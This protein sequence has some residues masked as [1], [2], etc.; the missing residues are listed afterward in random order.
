MINLEAQ[1]DFCPKYSIVTRGI[2]YGARMISSQ[3][4]TEFSGSNYD[5]IKKVYSIWIC[6]NV[7]RYIGN[8]I[9]EYSL[10]KQDIVQEMPD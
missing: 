8:T 2:Y 7:P 3:K 6:M 4:G 9:L 1:R 10:T 5:E